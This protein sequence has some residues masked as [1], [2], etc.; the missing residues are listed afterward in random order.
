MRNARGPA[1]WAVVALLT[2]LIGATPLSRAAEPHHGDHDGAPRGRVGILVM[3]HGEPPVYNADTYWSFRAF[4]D[5]LMEMEVI[6]SW[7][8]SLDLGTVLQD[9]ACYACPE[10]GETPH[11][12]DA[13]LR[14]HS[15]PAPL[16]VPPTSDSLPPHYVMAGGPGL[17]EPDIFE[18]AGL[19]VWDEW[20][21]M[22][23]RSPNYD[24]KLAK[25]RTLIARLKSLY[26][27]E[28]PIRVGYGID[29][30]IGGGRQ[31]IK[32]A[33]ETL[34]NRDRV[35][36]IVALYHGVGFSDIM[37]T[38]MLRHE[39]HATLEELGAKVA[40]RFAKPLGVS[41]HYTTAIVQKVQRELAVLPA[42]A[43]VAVHLSG[44]GLSTTTCG[45]YE[46]GE[47]AYHAYAKALFVRTSRAVKA[48]VKRPGRF[49]VYSVFADGSEGDVDPDNK[50]DSPMEGLRKRK[51]AGY[52]YVID[53]PYEFDSNSRDTLIILRNAYRRTIPDWNASYESSF[54]YDG[55]RVKIANANGG[56]DHK[57]A[58]FEDVAR[59]AIARWLGPR[60]TGSTSAHHHA[61]P[62]GHASHDEVT[63]A[64]GSSHHAATTARPV[65]PHRHG[66]VETHADVF[67]AHDVLAA[68]HHAAGPLTPG[69]GIPVPVV[70][71][72]LVAAGAGGIAAARRS[73]PL[74]ARIA[75]IAVGVQFAGFAWDGWLHH[76]AG[77]PI[78]WF[79]N[80]GHITVFLGLSL[81][82]LAAAQLVRAARN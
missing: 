82:G 11:L 32:Q 36:S 8:R 80:G 22:G 26:G 38:H 54:T 75:L 49:G 59:R 40:V 78:S 19:Q 61:S 48:A 76:R 10:P 41:A 73:A 60:T 20:R 43:A 25:K 34:V 56:D 45:G 69:T 15:P 79:E 47:D 39:V 28:T 42:D 37:Q 9:T 68:D 55:L 12:I 17:G 31:G 3:D 24:E 6:P 5:H 30:R 2:V 70:M 18:H 64:A 29:P 71:L 81:A 51:G 44:H 77:H 67:D 74:L 33:V 53:V 23:G 27:S 62:S 14:P 72:G 7:L 1:T 50:V 21:R 58:A 63:V 57:V 35:G 52:R 16:F 46:C 65:A 66:D 4:I 13:W